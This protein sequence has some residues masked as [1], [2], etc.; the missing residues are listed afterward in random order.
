VQLGGV[1]D[2]PDRLLF[3][4]GP[5][6]GGW[7]VVQACTSRGE[8]EA[9][10]DEH[11]RPALEALGGRGFPAPPVVTDLDPVLL[12]GPVGRPPSDDAGRSAAREL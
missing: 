4:A 9:F 10:D 3:A 1:P 12:A 8:L 7:Q 5:V 11:V 6:D 2:P